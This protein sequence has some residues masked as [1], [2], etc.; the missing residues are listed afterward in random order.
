MNNA[1]IQDRCI[2]ITLYERSTWIVNA[3]HDAYNRN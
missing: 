2:E 3:E 1:C